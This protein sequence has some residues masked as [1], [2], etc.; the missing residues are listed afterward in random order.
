M[1]VSLVN[2]DWDSR[3]G[4]QYTDLIWLIYDPFV[5][6]ILCG[7]N[8]I[9]YL[10]PTNIPIGKYLWSSRMWGFL[11]MMF[12]LFTFMNPRLRN[13]RFVIAIFLTVYRCPKNIEVNCLRLEVQTVFKYL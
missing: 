3:E 9:T 2:K 8:A 13:T 6:P 5:S 11:K 1:F 4:L 7:Y 10:N 12:M